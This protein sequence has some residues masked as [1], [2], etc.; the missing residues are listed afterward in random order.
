[1][2]E[3][4][5]NKIWRFIAVAFMALAFAA[6][7]GC[8]GGDSGDDGGGN[9]NT[10]DTTV[11]SITVSASS[12]SITTIGTLQFTAVA[13]N[14]AGNTLSSATITWTSSDANVAMIDGSS[15][16]VTGVGAGTTQITASSGGVISATFTLTVTLPPV[17]SITVTAAS[18]SLAI[19]QALQY[20][21]T[22]KDANNNTIPGVTFTWASSNTSAATINSAGLVSGVAI[23]IT[24]ITASSGGITSAASALEVGIIHVSGNISSN[25]T[26]YKE[27]IY[28]ID[29]SV[30]VYANITLTIEAGTVVKFASDTYLDIRGT[31]NAAGTSVA[32]IVFTS[33]AD[34]AHGGDTNGSATQPAIG[35]WKEVY[36]HGAL[37]NKFIYCDFYYGGGDVSWPAML[38]VDGASKADIDHCTF[39]H[40]E[41]SGLN[42][43]NA[44]KATTVTNNIFYD[45][46][47]PLCM[48]PDFSMGDT[49]AFFNPDNAAEGNDY[50]GIW[51]YGNAGISANRTWSYNPVPYVATGTFSVNDNVTLTVGTGVVVKLYAA[52]WVGVGIGS[53][54]SNLSNAIFTSYHDDVHDGDTDMDNG[55]TTPAKGDWEG[56]YSYP[57]GD[58]VS[59][60]S[61]LYATHP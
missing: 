7:T 60:A 47:K 19:G 27:N 46:S 36:L 54:V 8:G 24:Q 48:S 6:F 49:N 44:D 38:F 13:K 20:T 26:W 43:V 42:V 59:S 23:G 4:S 16:F 55:A 58:W 9:G 10:T 53:S 56:V 39:V 50:N 34:D 18:T 51:L 52:T 37:S 2:G 45:S 61:I 40:S 21:A 33:N 31:L 25:T 12:A 57:A 15:G 5:K 11:A 41:T 3:K 1:M 22:A 32:H 35:D 28:I 29:S 17:A 30:S 14:A